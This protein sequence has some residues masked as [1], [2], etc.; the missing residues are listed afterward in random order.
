MT[1]PNSLGR[2]LVSSLVLSWLLAAAAPARGQQV[3]LVRK[4]DVGAGSLLLRTTEP[5][6]YL[7]APRLKT[8]VQISVTG[9]I[10]RTRVTQRF[11]NPSDRWVEA[12]YVFPLPPDSGVDTL[13]MQ[14][15][16][17]LL[18]GEVQER[19]QA[20]AMYEVAA[21]AGK[22]ATL[23]EEQRPNVFTSSVANIGPRETVVVQIEYQGLVRLDGDRLSLRFPLVVAPRYGASGSEDAD[24]MTPAVLDP[25]VH[26]K[27]NPVQLSVELDAGVPFKVIE[28]PSH[29][30]EVKRG[31]GHAVWVALAGPVPADRDFVLDWTL[32]ANPS[33]QA[34]AFRETV[35]EETY[36]LA[37]IVPPLG[38]AAPQRLPRETIFVI[39][40]SGSMAGESMRQAKAAL[41]TALRDL[42]AGDWFNVIRFDDTL[43]LVFPSAVP[44]DAAHLRT[45][46]RFVEQLEARG[47]TEI[48]PALQAA[49][50]DS[51]PAAG[52]VRQVI[53]LTDG[54][55]G[56]ED[57]LLEE[58]ARTLGRSRI[59]TIGI[60]S[61]PNTFLM[62]HVARMGRGTFT[63]IGSESEVDQRVR[64]LLA[65]IESPVLTD[66]SATSDSG[67][68]VWPNPIPDLYAGEPVLLTAVGKGRGGVIHVAGRAGGTPW[69]GTLDLD[70]AADGRGIE[71]LWARAKIAAVEEWRFRG[72]AQADVDAEVLSV[73]LGHHLV[74]RLTSLVAVDVTPSRPTEEPLAK[75]GVPVN[76]PKGWDFEKVFGPGSPDAPRPSGALLAKLDAS[77][78]PKGFGSEG[79][80]PLPQTDLGSDQ[81]LALAALCFALGA[82]L[83]WGTVRRPAA[84]TC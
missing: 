17:R 24:L 4:A 15:G 7:E 66:L 37:M 73:A 54:E 23:V 16:D 30:I 39:D 53:F 74:S 44:A 21:A 14:V 48:F 27:T 67:V 70:S 40:N 10:V 28:S 57:Q 51:S 5:G 52:S 12:L 47:G 50:V 31:T 60:G 58:I 77:D 38:P 76:L 22:K 65:K 78:A 19:K 55:V 64:E 26:P 63:H 71:K 43:T 62:E 35:G 69:S 36:Y 34:A 59:F 11:Q 32:L 9:T 41:L 49:L 29:E 42:R 45:A 68:E 82:L 18:E 2:F 13:R 72:A 75:T 80:V 61:A 33:E 84:R 46:E 6:Q 83:L 20:R 1:H 79:G 25:A 81:Q 8:D 56:N 3:G